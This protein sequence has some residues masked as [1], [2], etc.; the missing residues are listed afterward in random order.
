MENL[1]KNSI[2][3]AA[4]SYYSDAELFKKNGSQKQ[5]M[6]FQKGVN[7]ND[8]P[9]FFKRGSYVQRRVVSG[10]L[11]KQELA[12]LPPK[13]KARTD[14]D[15]AFE[16]SVIDVVKMPP[17]GKVLNRDGVIFFGEE[18]RTEA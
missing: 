11:T 14:P 10:K 13:H 7:W 18:P 8:Y 9:D 16:R 17:F 5:E 4:R 3:M 1:S 2:T 6:L 12:D 15:F